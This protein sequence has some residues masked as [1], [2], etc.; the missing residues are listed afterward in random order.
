MDA[1]QAGGRGWLPEC[2]LSNEIAV[3]RQ[4]RRAGATTMSVPNRIILRIDI[5]LNRSCLLSELESKREKAPERQAK[6]RGFQKLG[7]RG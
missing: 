2:V 4:L 7:S 5:L 1:G 6:K 3:Q